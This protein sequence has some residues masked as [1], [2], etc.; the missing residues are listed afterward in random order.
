MLEALGCWMIQRH[1]A[2]LSLCCAPYRFGCFGSK[3]GR[4]AAYFACLP[5]RT[6]VALCAGVWNCCRAV[7][8]LV[9]GLRD[10]WYWERPVLSLAFLLTFFFLWLQPQFFPAAFLL[11]L[12]RVADS[13]FC[14]PVKHFFLLMLL[15]IRLF[16]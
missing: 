2:C 8:V 4:L 5:L 9:E 14:D 10:A 16:A 11:L 15:L 7:G 12:V 3:R 1:F 6:R 13:S